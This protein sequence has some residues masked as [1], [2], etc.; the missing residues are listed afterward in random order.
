[1]FFIV[2]TF[3]G[4]V[5]PFGYCLIILVLVYYCI[6][7]LVYMMCLVGFIIS[8]PCWAQ[9]DYSLCDYVLV[10]VNTPH[11]LFSWLLW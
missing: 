6:L 4:Y 8:T 11:S 3:R 5:H 7:S 10:P 1:M 9:V 2:Y